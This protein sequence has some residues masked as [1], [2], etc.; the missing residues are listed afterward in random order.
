MLYRVIRGS[1]GIMAKKMET[2][3]VYWASMERTLFFL[4]K[5][6]GGV[7]VDAGNKLAHM[8]SSLVRSLRSVHV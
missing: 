4:A 7:A 6:G 5:G 8:P 3:M 1:I 2:T